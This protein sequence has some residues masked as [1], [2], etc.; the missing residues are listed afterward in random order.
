M[1]L[2][3]GQRGCNLRWTFLGQARELGRKTTR[4]YLM[5][6]CFISGHNIQWCGAERG[7]VKPAADRI[8]VDSICNLHTVVDSRL[9]IQSTEYSSIGA[10]EYCSTRTRL[11]GSNEKVYSIQYTVHSCKMAPLPRP[12]H[13][14]E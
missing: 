10:L 4:K 6:F 1:P 12:M 2:R 9:V 14:S 11:G 7:R 3:H 8:L 5:Y 13:S